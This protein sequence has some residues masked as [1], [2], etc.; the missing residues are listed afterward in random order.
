MPQLSSEQKQKILYDI[1]TNMSYRSVGIK[2]K[3]SYTIV[4]R[5]F[6]KFSRDGEKS[7]V[8]RSGRKYK[9]EKYEIL[10]MKRI[11]NGNTFLCGREVRDRA[12][13]NNKIL[14]PTAKKVHE[15]ARPILAESQ[16]YEFP[17]QETCRKTPSIL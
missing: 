4:S 6:K 9:L 5:I 17:Q 3:I 2:Y 8:S 12:L 13:L 14:I 15:R 7:L 10:R 16:M 1:S 11:S